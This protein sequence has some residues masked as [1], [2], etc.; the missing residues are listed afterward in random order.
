MS[1]LVGG[2]IY[3]MDTTPRSPEERYGPA[4]LKALEGLK[5]RDPH[6]V[7]DWA[8]VEYEAGAAGQGQL[9]VR[10]WDST[11][12]VSYPAG[13]VL[14]REGKEPP[15]F[16]RLVILHYLLTAVGVP[17][18]DRWIAF[19]ELPGGLGYDAAFQARVNRRLAATFG[20]K[21][22]AF[23]E[24]GLA[25]GG[26]PLEVGDAAFAF[27]L[28]PRLRVAVVI[29]RGD[30]EFPA[31]ANLI[32]DGA[33]DRCLPTEDLVVLGELVASRLARFAASSKPS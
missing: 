22:S 33:A 16:V 20:Q 3:S 6:V 11:Y 2:P 9:R 14:D 19:R 30:D 29:Y 25:L 7:A 17:M 24:A 8:G 28:F 15:I 12:M 23:K 13:R 26:M 21:L 1:K 10:Y 4:L 18:A 32:F 5:G 31:S 27:D